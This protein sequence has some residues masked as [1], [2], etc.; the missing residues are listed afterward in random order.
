[1]NSLRS[2]LLLGVSLLAIVPLALAMFVMS[3]QVSTRLTHEAGQRLEIALDGL[4][5]EMSADS[6]RAAE[7]VRILAGDAQLRRLYLVNTT[8]RGE[9]GAFLA[10]RRFLLSL[11]ELMVLDTTGAMVAGDGAPGV[12]LDLLLSSPI[13][14]QG[15]RVGDLAGGRV[16]NAEFLARLKRATALDLAL[17]DDSSHVLAS[18]LDSA[19]IVG[20]ARPP[21][22]LTRIDLAG[23]AYLARG[24]PLAH[25][26]QRSESIVGLIPMAEDERVIATLQWTSLVLGLFGL[27]FALALGLVWSWQVSR[28]V[29]ELAAF[30]HRIAGGEWDDPLIVHG[31]R[32]LRTLG[33]A[34]E[35]MRGELRGYRDRLVVSERQAAWGQ[36]AR[37]VAHEVKNPLTPI[38]ISVADLR[39]SFEQKRPDFPAILDQATRTIAEEIETLKR[40]LQEF[41]EFG[42]M[43]PPRLEACDLGALL[44]GLEALHAREVADGRL[45]IE[46]PTREVSFTADPGQL[47][48][49]LLNL[50]KNA[51]EAIGPDGHVRVRAAASAGVLELAVS[52]DGPGLTAE[53]RDQLFVPGFST[54][55]DGSGLGLT[56]VERIVSDHRG[57]VRVDSPGGGGTTF[58]VLLPLRP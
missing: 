37:K 56:I 38:A 23:G 51:L 42:R 5:A 52:D 46:H 32:E 36:M 11:D 21:E 43:Q 29:E 41:S 44:G 45:A 8:D 35:S 57:T 16:V 18:T 19:A 15:E 10:E 58:R 34:L 50:V 55:P 49:A 25:R 30:S 40:L 48:Q 4:R 7:K 39:S 17:L 22:R 47:R 20:L 33:D 27:A 24:L 31:G 2:R 26:G 54:K 14:Y 28:P 13:L 6:V 3:R 12:G 1:M 9:L 53:Q